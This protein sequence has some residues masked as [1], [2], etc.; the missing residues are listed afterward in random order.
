MLPSFGC[1][2]Y[3]LMTYQLLGTFISPT[4]SECLGWRMGTCISDKLYNAGG[5]GT[6]I[7][8]QLIRGARVL[9]NDTR[10]L[11]VVVV[12]GVGQWCG[13]GAHTAHCL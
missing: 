2:N 3:N 12:S 13:D 4:D 7:G 9:F 11:A 1:L 8:N 5:L 10:L 6:M